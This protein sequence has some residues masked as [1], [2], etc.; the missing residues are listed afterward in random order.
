MSVSLLYI[1]IVNAVLIRLLTTINIFLRRFAGSRL[2]T[3][4]SASLLVSDCH[5]LFLRF[6]LQ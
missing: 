5:V 4:A 1:S 2:E 6:E 3:T